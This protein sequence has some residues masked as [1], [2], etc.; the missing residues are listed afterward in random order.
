LVN[1]DSPS[2][3]SAPAPDSAPRPEGR[4]EERGGGGG[5]SFGGGGFGGGGGG[6]GRGFGGG[7]RGGFSRRKVCA[8][9]VDKIEHIDYKDPGKLRRYITERGK[10]EPRRKTGTCARHQRRLTVAIKRARQIAL[11]PFTAGQARFTIP[12]AAR[13][14][15]TRDEAV[16]PAPAAEA[17]APA[18]ASVES[19]PPPDSAESPAPDAQTATEEAA[20]DS[21][22]PA[23][24]AAVESEPVEA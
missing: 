2:E 24:P 12:P 15:Q 5:R 14:D 21:S 18:E 3:R 20:A 13:R 22:A 1:E 6:G 19:P 17:A 11:L 10:I 9:C 4:T 16:A 7:R 23:E 8:F